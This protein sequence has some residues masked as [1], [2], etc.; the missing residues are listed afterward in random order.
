MTS[1]NATV[2]TTALV[3]TSVFLLQT[4]TQ[5]SRPWLV[6]RASFISIIV[7]RFLRSLARQPSCFL[8]LPTVS[9]F[10]GLLVR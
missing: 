7:A 2:S 3:F 9:T 5:L 8:H 10:N 4:K 6:T 1:S